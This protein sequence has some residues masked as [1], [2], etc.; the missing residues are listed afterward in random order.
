[1][2]YDQRF[3][4]YGPFPPTPS[5][6]DN[7]PIVLYRLN[8]DLL[9]LSGYG[10]FIGSAIAPYG[11]GRIGNPASGGQRTVQ[12]GYQAAQLTAINLLL[13]VQQLA[14]GGSLNGVW[15]VISVE[16]HVSSTDDFT[17]QSEVLNGC[18][19]LL[20]SVFGDAG[21]H[22]RSAIGVN[23]LAFGISV[24]IAMT[25]LVQPRQK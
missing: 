13:I 15:R 17:Q 8:G 1:M 20:L 22:T 4:Q 10:P 19:N 23:T 11:Q 7:L 16:G 9:T 14:L 18:S 6:P 12:E 24:E 3:A 21:R 2:N 5:V 25:L